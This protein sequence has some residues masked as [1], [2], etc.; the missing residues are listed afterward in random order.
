MSIAKAQLSDEEKRS[1]F[2]PRPGMELGHA[3]DFPPGM[4]EFSQI[5]IW[6]FIRLSTI[7]SVVMIL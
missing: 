3:T 4:E 6:T 5:S 2:L 1:R 7:L